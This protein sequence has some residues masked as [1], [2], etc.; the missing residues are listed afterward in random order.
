MPVPLLRSFNRLEDATSAREQLIAAGLSADAVQ[1]R[2]V[3][4]EAGPTKGNF[5]VG[6]GREGTEPYDKNFAHPVAHGTHLLLVQ[7]R[8]DAEHQRASQLLDGM[9]A[10]RADPAGV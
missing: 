1:L 8:D 10:T 3:D 5:L 2:V 6:N 4:D 9:G 7:P